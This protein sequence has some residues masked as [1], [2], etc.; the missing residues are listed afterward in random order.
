LRLTLVGL[1]VGA[2]LSILLAAGLAR[3]WLG[4]A[5][6]DPLTHLAVAVVLALTT[7]AAALLPAWHAGRTSVVEALRQE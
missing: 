3:A 2:M 6:A 1:G 5:P 7:F 4:V